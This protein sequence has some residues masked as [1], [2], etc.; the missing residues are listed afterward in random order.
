MP[1]ER[2]FR[3]KERGQNVNG[4][5]SWENPFSL[6]PPVITYYTPTNYYN[7]IE[8]SWSKP[9]GAYTFKVQYANNPYFTDSRT[10]TTTKT[11]AKIVIPN[12]TWYWRVQAVYS[13][14]GSVFSAPVKTYVTPE[15]MAVGML[16]LSLVFYFRRKNRTL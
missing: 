8:G 5:D 15:P 13:G 4:A 7:Y 6:E 9:E 10:E 16:A 1:K 3:L 12:G 2:S 11:E 14:G